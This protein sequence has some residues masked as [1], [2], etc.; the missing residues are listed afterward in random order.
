MSYERVFYFMSRY[1]IYANFEGQEL[2]FKRYGENE[3]QVKNEFD[4]FVKEKMT[5]WNP[6]IEKI[7]HDKTK[8]VT[9]PEKVV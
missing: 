2:I 8:S 7:E 3:E 6:V 9:V 4:T 5:G 1:K